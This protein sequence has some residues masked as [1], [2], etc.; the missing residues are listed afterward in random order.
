[1]LEDP[2]ALRYVG[3]QTLLFVPNLEWTIETPYRKAAISCPLYV[4]SKMQWV[5]EQAEG[6]LATLSRDSPISVESSRV[7]DVKQAEDALASAKAIE[8]SHAHFQIPE[9]EHS[10]AL[11]FAVYIKNDNTED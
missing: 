2:D 9:F 8:S 6:M 3:E 4:T 10:D 7:K 1:M 11:T 5:L